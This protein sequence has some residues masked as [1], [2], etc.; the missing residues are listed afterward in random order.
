MNLVNG[1]EEMYI[2][3]SSNE[4]K[5]NINNLNELYE[6]VKKYESDSKNSNDI[7]G[8]AKETYDVALKSIEISHVII[9]ILKNNVVDKVYGN[10]FINILINNILDMK[11]YMIA[12]MKHLDKSY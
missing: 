4:L 2:K 9:G 10:D 7:K 3:I 8:L 1:K 11:A 5:T 6:K 12:Y